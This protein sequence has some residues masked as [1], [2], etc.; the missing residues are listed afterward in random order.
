MR[1]FLKAPA[2]ETARR[3][4]TERIAERLRTEKG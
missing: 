1:A 2:A 4:G 3:P